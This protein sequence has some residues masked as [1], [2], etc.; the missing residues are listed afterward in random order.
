MKAC[1][2]PLHD[3]GNENDK[4]SKVTNPRAHGLG[5]VL[6]VYKYL[7]ADRRGWPKHIVN[8][9]CV[10]LGVCLKKEEFKC[11]LNKDLQIPLYEKVHHLET[12][13]S[14]L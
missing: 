10:C 3:C 4:D 8:S 12:L 7:E 1:Q 2:N 14:S 6:N 13:L 9:C 5:D 11:N